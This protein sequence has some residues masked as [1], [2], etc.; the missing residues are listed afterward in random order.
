MRLQLFLVA[1]LLST[2]VFAQIDGTQFLDCFKK[3]TQEV[4]VELKAEGKGK[5][6]CSNL[7]QDNVESLMSILTDVDAEEMSKTRA[8]DLYD[9]LKNK[10]ECYKPVTKD[11]GIIPDFINVKSYHQNMNLTQRA[12]SKMIGTK[13]FKE[14]YHE[15][16][17]LDLSYCVQ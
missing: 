9:V 15:L 3:A 10:V 1:S 4:I 16:A 8:I 14:G 17:D 2:N 5:G 13:V 11:T 6:I 12:L 7:S